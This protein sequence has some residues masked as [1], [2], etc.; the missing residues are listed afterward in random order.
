MNQLSR[1]Q[2]ARIVSALVEGN[3]LRATARMCNV[4]FNTVL[5]LLPQ[6]GAACGE[7]QDK[8][9]R[10]LT[11]RRIQC[12]EIWSFCYAKEQKVP[13]DKRGELGFGIF[14]TSQGCLIR[15]ESLPPC[16]RQARSKTATNKPSLQNR[17]FL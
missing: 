4:A 15:N 9:L 6:I 3:R 5:R 14:R 12:D 2:R 11:S 7:Y 13:A 8:A 1:E 10:N 17:C 16:G